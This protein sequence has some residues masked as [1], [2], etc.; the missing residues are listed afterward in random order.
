MEKFIAVY[1]MCNLLFI[2]LS[3]LLYGVLYSF[4][5]TKNK[6]IILEKFIDEKMNHKLFDIVFYVW[7]ISLMFSFLYLWAKEPPIIP[8]DRSSVHSFFQ[9]IFQSF[10]HH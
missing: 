8:Y 9:S 5:H 7:I 3:A 6:L 10:F 4:S 1:F 2:M